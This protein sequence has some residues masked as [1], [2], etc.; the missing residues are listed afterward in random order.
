MFDEY[1]NPP[2][3][4]DLYAPAV[5]AQELIVLTSTPSSTTT[6]QDALSI[7]TSQTTPKT[8]SHVIPIGVEEADND[9]KV[10]HMDNSPFVEVLIP[11]PSFE[12]SST[13]SY[14]DALMESCWIEAMQ[15]ELNELEC[16]EVWKLVPHPDCVM[17]ITLKWIYKVKLDELGVSQLEAIRIFIAFTAHMNMV[18]Y[19][20]DVKTAF[21]NDILREEVYVSQPDGFVDTH[22]PNHVYKLKKALYGLKQ[23]PH[24]LETTVPQKEETF[25]VIIDLIKNSSCFK[26]FTSSADVLEIFMPGTPSRRVKDVDFTRTPDH[27]ASLAF[28]IK[29]GYK[30]LLY[31]HTNM[32]VDHMHQ[33]WRTLA[34]II[35]KCLSG[36]TASNDKLRKLITGRRR[37][38]DVKNAIP[39]IHQ[40]HHQ[41]LPQATQVPLKKSRGKGSQR[42]KT[43][44]DSQETVDV[45][46]EFE[47]E[48]KPVK[49]KTSNVAL[50]LGK[51]ISK[52]EA[53]KAETARQV[54]ATHARIVTESVLEPTRRIKSGKVTFDP[55]KKLK[56][57]PSL[58]LEELE[59]VDNMQALKESRKTSRRQHG[60]EGSNERTST[61]PEIPDESTVIFATS[62]DGTGSEQES[63][64][65][66]EDQLGDKEK[67]EKDG[68]ADDEGDDY[69]SNNQDAD[70]EDAETEFDEDEI[71]KYKIRVHKD[72]DVEM[73]NAKVEDSD[74]GDEEVTDAAKENSEKTS[75][76]KDDAKKTELPPTSSI[77]SEQDK[78]Q[79]MSKFTIKSTDKVALKEFYHKSA[80]YQTIHSN[81]SFNRNLANQKLYH[82]LIEALIEDENATDKGVVD[83]VKDHKR[84]HDNDED[85]DDEDPPVR[86]N[87][88]KKTERIR[89]ND[90]ESS[91]KP[92]TFKETPKG[93][94]LSKG[95]KT[96]KFASTKEPVEE[97]CAE[98]VMDDAG[99]DVVRDDDQPQDASEPM[100]TK[101][102][103]PEWFTQPSLLIQNGTSVR[104][105]LDN[106]EGDRYP[107][108]LSKPLPLQ[109]HLGHLTIAVDY[110]SNNDLEY[111]KSFDPE[112]TYTTSITKTKVARYKTER[113][114][115]MVPTL[116]SPTKVGEFPK[117]L[118]INPPQLTFPEIEFKELYIPSHK[119]PGA[120]PLEAF[121]LLYSS[122]AADAVVPNHTPKDLAVTTPS[123]KVL[124][125]PEAS[126][127]KRASTSRSAP[128]QVSKRIRSS[129]ANSSGSSRGK[130]IMDNDVDI[131]SRSVGHPYAYVGPT[132]LTRD[133]T[134]DAIDKDF[135]PFVPGPYY[136]EYLEDDI[137]V[138]HLKDKTGLDASAK[139][140]RAKLNAPEMLN[141][142]RTNQETKDYASKEPS[143]TRSLLSLRSLLSSS[144]SPRKFTTFGA[145]CG[146]RHP[147]LP[148]RKEPNEEFVDSQPM[149]EEFQGVATRDTGTETRRGP[150]EPVLQTKKSLLLLRPSSKK[151]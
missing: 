130:A 30:V 62:S 96:G 141:Y 90:L 64:Y 27:D 28:L 101:T 149:E 60:Y 2:P 132:P 67:D 12:E 40:N 77:L 123:I 111:L 68:D 81:K 125:K 55:P 127:K 106:P 13:E 16:L 147:I 145:N 99:K 93:R 15:E 18:V 128:S 118:N 131:S 142:R 66:K 7:S 43:A 53:G 137:I 136:A 58:T 50:E 37:D 74:K 80:L 115:D 65:S 100:K 151:T 29:L 46:K 8:P 6:D 126:K 47:P 104:L 150:T 108:D 35:K 1:L 143:R 54:Y 61:I 134:S 117:K 113:I 86:P 25:Q 103:N 39:S 76:V 107:F 26:A 94:A 97:Q 102:P 20:M 85:D 116:W 124:A 10:A 122:A 109:G 63:E 92:S 34:T 42:K 52:T 144:S 83:T 56:G 70:D 22:D 148:K 9:I 89:T 3:S 32:F 44:N 119:P 19:Q 105:D 24:A 95:S 4:V 79:K 5:I 23:A 36:Q 17:I 31:K 72:E 110:F 21:L 75:K 120:H 59:V 114:E 129:T 51:L 41:S 82:D 146:T 11:G 73:S 121:F 14:K 78:K 57:V 133:L 33:P 87:L 71:Y 135:F 84:K 49:R 88:G 112:R 138:D 38:Q 140:T 45:S 98:V 48:P 91:K 139:I 69:I